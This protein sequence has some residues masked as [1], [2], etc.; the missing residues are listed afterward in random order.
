MYLWVIKSHETKDS[1][2]ATIFFRIYF[3][4][5]SSRSNLNRG[6]FLRIFLIFCF[7]AIYL[8]DKQLDSG[9]T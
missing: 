4:S 8:S 6:Q 1:S 7:K 2:L 5:A 3:L 9:Y